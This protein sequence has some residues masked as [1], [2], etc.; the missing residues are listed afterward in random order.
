MQLFRELANSPPRTENR[1]HQHRHHRRSRAKARYWEG[2]PRDEF[3]RGHTSRIRASAHD[4][5]VRPARRVELNVEE[6][7][8]AYPEAQHKTR[9]RTASTSRRFVVAQRGSPRRKQ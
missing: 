7:L 5:S 8:E 3:R 6:A 1:L 9:A 2:E 4:G